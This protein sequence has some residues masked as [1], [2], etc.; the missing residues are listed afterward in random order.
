MRGPDREVGDGLA[1]DVEEV[2]G[3]AIAEVPELALESVH[4]RVVVAVATEPPFETDALFK[5]QQRA[6][7]VDGGL[8][9]RTVAYNARILRK[10][11][12]RMSRWL[13]KSPRVAVLLFMRR[14]DLDRIG[15]V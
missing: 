15:C 9:L 4:G 6:R 1:Y 7:V 10:R 11:V 3:A 8:N 5:A 2:V 12:E 14:W 13:L